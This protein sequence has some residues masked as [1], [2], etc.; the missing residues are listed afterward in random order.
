MTTLM[1]HLDI[2]DEDQEYSQEDLLTLAS[3]EGLI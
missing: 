3:I 2:F 1:E